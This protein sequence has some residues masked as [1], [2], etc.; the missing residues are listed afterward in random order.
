M[1]ENHDKFLQHLE[2]SKAGVWRAAMWLVEHGYKVSINPTDKAPSAKEW[3]E[4]ADSGDI[5]VQLRVEVKHLSCDFT[6]VH[7]WEDQ[8]KQVQGIEKLVEKERIALIVIDSFVA[9]YRLELDSENFQKINK[10]LATQ[11]SILSRITRKYKI[12]IVVTNQVYGYSEGGDEK[13][14][15]TSRTIAKYWSKALI[16][17]KRAGR[18][19]HRIA[20]VRKH[21]SIAE[22]KNIEFEIREKDLKEAGKLGFF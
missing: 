16:E 13:I 6:D 21:R 18:S 5:E 4:Y 17:L 3:R 10:Q 7:S 2:E 15:L 1:T 9:L 11:Y 19:N 22:G 20:I 8:H 12:P 14:E